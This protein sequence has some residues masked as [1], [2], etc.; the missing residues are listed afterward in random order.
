M[1]SCRSNEPNLRIS[2]VTFAIIN[3]F[4]RSDIKYGKQAD[5]SADDESVG[6]NSPFPSVFNDHKND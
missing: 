3:W 4:R 2:W 1:T 5:T 6:E